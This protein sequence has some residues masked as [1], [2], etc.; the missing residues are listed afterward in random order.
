M[1]EWWR[2]T[3]VVTFWIRIQLYCCC[4]R[5][6][7]LKGNKRFMLKSHQ[8]SAVTRQETSNTLKPVIKRKKNLLPYLLIFAWKLL[9][10]DQL[11]GRPSTQLMAGVVGIIKS[12]DCCAGQDSQWNVNISVS[13]ISNNREAPGSEAEASAFSLPGTIKGFPL[14]L[15][16]IIHVFRIGRALSRLYIDQRHMTAARPLYTTVA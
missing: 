5:N 6:S 10:G 11:P 12:H 1:S 16:C 4:S 13:M 3:W 14:S 9:P 7:N 8:R 15:H 2:R